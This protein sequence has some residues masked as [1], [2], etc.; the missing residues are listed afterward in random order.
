MK[1][2]Q[3]QLR[4]MIR[5]AMDDHHPLESDDDDGISPAAQDLIQQLAEQIVSDIAQQEDVDEDML[6]SEAINFVTD[7]VREFFDAFYMR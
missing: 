1:L 4:S 2:S 5:E 7:G 6:H 3:G